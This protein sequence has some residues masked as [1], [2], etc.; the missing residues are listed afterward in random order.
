MKSAAAV[1]TGERSIEIR[2]FDVPS[3]GADDAVLRVEAT[4]VCGADF[5]PLYLGR[6]PQPRIG[7]LVLGH[8]IAGRIHH[9]GDEATSRWGVAEGDLVVVEEDVPCGRCRLCRSGR[10][11]MCNGLA[12]GEGRRYGFTSVDVAP[13]LWGGFSDF[14]Y[15]SPNSVVHRVPDG[16][17][18]HRAPLFLPISNGVEWVQRYGRLP[19]GG[20]VVVQGPGQHGLGCV[21]AASEAGASMIIVSGAAN[22]ARRLELAKRLGADAVVDVSEEP[23][24]ERV[25]E[26]TG[27]L[28]VDVVVDATHGAAAPVR[29]GVRMAA[30]GGVVVVAGL[31]MGRVEVDTDALIVKDVSLVGANGHDLVSVGAALRIL[32]DDQYPFDVLCTHTFTVPEAERA[33]MTVGGEGDPD[34]VHVTV[35]PA[36]G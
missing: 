33:V 25:R 5:D 15:L 3:V 29:D 21:I 34:P 1:L 28:G 8:E 2:D 32:E 26:L 14:M 20:T 10:Y 24:V 17:P 27:G 9:I 4:G 36:H 31:K 12:G 22:D 11:R 7:P 19:P 13:H 6:G 18:A 35:V 30:V 23:L 16:V